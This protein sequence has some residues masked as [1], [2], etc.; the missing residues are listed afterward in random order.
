MS[1]SFTLAS[2]LPPGVAVA[3]IAG[4]APC[5]LLPEEAAE[6]GDV[7]AKRRRDFTCGRECARR[8]LRELGQAVARDLRAQILY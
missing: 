7:S 6:L 1:D 5:A 3:E 4:D 2:L 8:A